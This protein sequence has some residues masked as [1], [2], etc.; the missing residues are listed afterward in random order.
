M[1][2]VFYLNSLKKPL[3]LGESS[4]LAN[5]FLN[6]L[7]DTSTTCNSIR[8][9]DLID[10]CVY[11]KKISCPE[12]SCDFAKKTITILLNETFDKKNMSYY[13]SL[14]GHEDLEASYNEPCLGDRETGYY[15]HN[16]YGRNIEFKIQLC[17]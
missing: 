2:F 5:N 12:S 13:F 11:D 17:K 8:L 9:L 1:L 6:V 7:V 10:D 16:I 3:N 15:P 14:S 4:L